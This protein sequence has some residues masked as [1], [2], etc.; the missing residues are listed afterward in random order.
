METRICEVCKDWTPKY[1]Q[2][3]Y[4]VTTMT[5]GAC[6]DTKKLGISECLCHAYEPSECACDAEWGDYA[7]WEDDHELSEY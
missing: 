6:N 3:Y 7:Y 1:L 5:C 2:K 4:G